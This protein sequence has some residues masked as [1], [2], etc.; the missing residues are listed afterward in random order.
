MRSR[1]A[2]LKLNIDKTDKF[3]RTSEIPAKNK[4]IEQT[5]KINDN[6]YNAYTDGSRINNETEFAVCIF[7][8]NKPYQDSLYRLNPTNSDFQA[9][10]V[11]IDL[12]PSGF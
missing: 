10:L 6:T 12:L 1:E 2:Q 11:A 9:E 8:S 5:V 3:I 4:I 7:K